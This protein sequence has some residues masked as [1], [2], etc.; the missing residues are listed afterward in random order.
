MVAHIESSFHSCWP[1][2]RAVRQLLPTEEFPTRRTETFLAVV[3][4]FI[5]DDGDSIGT[6]TIV[7]RNLEVME[8]KDNKLNL[9]ASMQ[10]H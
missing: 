9:N 8:G 4:A 2:R 1:D 10:P 5:S 6:E 3:L 7:K